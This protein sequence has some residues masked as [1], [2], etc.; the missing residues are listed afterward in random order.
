[1]GTGGEAR[2]ADVAD[3]IAPTD[4]CAFLSFKARHVQIERRQ[5][6]AMIDSHCAAVNIE[7][8]HDANH[9]VRDSADWR[10]LA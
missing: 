1:M 9:S 10:A 5:A 6:L 2:R 3:H 8:L 4:T 7:H